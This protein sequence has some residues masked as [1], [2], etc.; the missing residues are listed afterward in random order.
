MPSVPGLAATLMTLVVAAPVVLAQSAPGGTETR[1]GAP[2]QECLQHL[3][4]FGQ[5]MNQDG[6][7]LSGWPASPDGKLRALYS[8]ADVLAGLGEQEI[9]E[10]VLAKARGLYASSIAQLQQRGVQ[11]SKLRDHRRERIDRAVPVAKMSEPYRLSGLTGTDVRNGAD[12]YLGSVEDVIVD[13]RTGKPSYLLIGTGGFLGI[14]EELVGVPWEQLRATPEMSTLI[15]NVTPDLLE[16]A[17]R[18]DPRQFVGV[19]AVQQQERVDAYWK[20]LPGGG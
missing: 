5:T 11:T 6:Y 3:R 1:P 15:L 7:A 12:E 8:A 10:A 20:R 4:A 16:K 9:C 17:P 18:L 19:I 13:P 2:G 14:G